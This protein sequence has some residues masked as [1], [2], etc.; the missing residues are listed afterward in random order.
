MGAPS[1]RR[2]IAV[3]SV[4]TASLLVPGPQPAV[5]H[6]S[7]GPLLI[8][9]PDGD[10][11]GTPAQ[12]YPLP[13]HDE[14]AIGDYAEFSP[15]GSE[16][17]FSSSGFNA[18]GHSVWIYPSEGS[19]RKVTTVPDAE[20]R[21][22]IWSPDG[23]TLAFDVVPDEPDNGVTA[24]I[25]TV[26]ASGGEAELLSSLPETTPG[27][28]HEGS[29]ISWSPDGSTIAFIG[30]GTTDEDFHPF[31]G[32]L[33]V[34]TGVATKR[35]STDIQYFPGSE[36][37]RHDQYTAIDYLPDGRLAVTGEWSEQTYTPDDAP[38]DSDMEYDEGYYVGVYTM[39][40]PHPHNL[41][42]LETEAYV[43]QNVIASPD[44][45]HIAWDQESDDGSDEGLWQ[46]RVMP[47]SGGA[48]S[49][50]TNVYTDGYV[51]DWQPCPGGECA[52][53]E[54][55]MD[56]STAIQGSADVPHGQSQPVVAQVTSEAG[57][58]TGSVTATLDGKSLGT[59]T[60]VNGHATIELPGDLAMGS[61]T[62]VVSYPGGD[63]YGT[64]SATKTFNVKARS[65]VKGR[66]SSAIWTART[67]P[68]INGTLTVTPDAVATGTMQLL[69]DG[70]VTRS[71]QLA[72]DMN[73]TF[74]L[75]LSRMTVGRHTVQL[76]YLGSATV[77][78]SAS[79]IANVRV[80]P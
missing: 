36:F 6:G 56:T 63:G 43:P 72:A 4:L 7:H 69:V 26:P 62:L 47:S 35:T 79:G 77:M 51:D 32:T 80:I 42:V 73:N 13:Y 3:A 65:T 16:I 50:L 38:D 46:W 22:I 68:W 44:G 70:K 10:R 52:T 17:A 23:D 15:D 14:F 34:N 66:L 28:F 75:K 60:L 64:S 31:I 2:S 19:P 1:L 55:S 37:Q 78:P 29:G 67:Q 41:L 58:P 49:E 8:G 33:N 48:W 40:Q 39:G 20:V 5:A 54:A 61:H 24:G 25:Y 9:Q 12:S 30:H 45:S 74:Y 57:T 11:I 59:F 71:F 76:K 18:P 53:F 27:S 21:Q